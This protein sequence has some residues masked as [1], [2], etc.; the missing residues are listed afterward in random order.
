M[1]ADTP[2]ELEGRGP[3]TSNSRSGSTTGSGFSSTAESSDQRV[4]VV[5]SFT[6]VGQALE[7][8]LNP[9]LAG[10]AAPMR[11]IGVG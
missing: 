5:L 8:V 6:L 4:L 7:E 1:V 10:Q 11:Q 9:R 2:V 3:E